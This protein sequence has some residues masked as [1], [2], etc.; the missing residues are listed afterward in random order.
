M[1]IDAL[2]TGILFSAAA[3]I[4]VG[5]SQAPRTFAQGS[6]EYLDDY[7]CRQEM[8]RGGATNFY[9]VPYKSYADCRAD[10]I[11]IGEMLARAAPSPSVTAQAA[12]PPAVV[13]RGPPQPGDLGYVPQAVAPP[14]LQ[15]EVHCN[16][17]NLGM[18]VSHTNCY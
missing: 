5:C 12:P 15:P 13:Y 6:S 7:Q 18:G 3:L 8:A 4:L 2:R 16:T 1:T 11:Y 14:P 9:G 10:K 17:T